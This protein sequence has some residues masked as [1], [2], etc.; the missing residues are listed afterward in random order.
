[1]GKQ[2][3]WGGLFPSSSAVFDYDYDDDDEDDG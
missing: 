1:M 2:P 3:I